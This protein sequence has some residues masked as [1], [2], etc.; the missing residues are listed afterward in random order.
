MLVA[1]CTGA[2]VVTVGLLGVIVMT[3]TNIT[4]PALAM[5]PSTAVAVMVAVPCEDPATTTPEAGS[6]EI[7]EGAELIQ[8]IVGLRALDGDGWGSE[9]GGVG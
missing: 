4:R 5:L 7:T 3:P 8:T 2:A 1:S 6:M 9:R